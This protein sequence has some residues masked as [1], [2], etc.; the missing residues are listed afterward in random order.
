MKIKMM[1]QNE[2]GEMHE[3]TAKTAFV[4][5]MSSMNFGGIKIYNV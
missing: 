4:W 5:G 3:E 2:L 1:T